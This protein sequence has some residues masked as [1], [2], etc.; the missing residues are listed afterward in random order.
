MPFKEPTVEAYREGD[1][2]RLIVSEQE[3]LISLPIARI[4]C[5]LLSITVY[6]ES[7][8]ALMAKRKRLLFEKEELQEKI[9]KIC[10]Y[11]RRRE[12]KLKCKSSPQV[13]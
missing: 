10:Q 11:Y 3:Y 9:Q 8:I 5:D 12:A 6:D 4:I 7:I 2:I 1:K 13:L